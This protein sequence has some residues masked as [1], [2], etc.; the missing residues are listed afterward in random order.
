MARL[1]SYHEVVGADRSGLTQQV[2]AQRAK[3]AAR[4]E[5][6]RCTVAVM[7]GKG[8]V[9]KSFVTAGL[10]LALARRSASGV[11]V[12]D[13]DLH[14]PTAARLLDASGR[15]EIVRGAVR[16]VRGAG[17]VRVFSTDLLLEEDTPLRWREPAGE[18]FVW[19]GALEAGVIR[20]FLSDIAWGELDLLLVDLPPGAAHLRD[21][22]EVLPTLRGAVAVT[23]P[24]EESRRSVAR[25]M[26]AARTSDVELLGVVE[27]MTGYVCGSCGHEQ[28]LFEGRAGEELARRFGIPLLGRIPLTPSSA[29]GARAR[30]AVP[31]VIVDRFVEVLAI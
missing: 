9:G 13:A 12:L 19:R 15:L 24:S 26:D 7:S 18:G 21:L 4:L 22:V 2:A 1:R 28:P 17:D 3:V 31:D 27:N 30:P 6:V 11:G 23:I 16:P 20:E 5:R 8:G 29:T 10:A 14:G 25:A